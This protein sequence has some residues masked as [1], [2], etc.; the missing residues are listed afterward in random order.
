MNATTFA[1]TTSALIAAQST[2]QSLRI[3]LE[4]LNERSYSLCREL[5]PGERYPMDADMRRAFPVYAENE[6]KI[7]KVV[8]Q[9]NLLERVWTRA[10]L[11]G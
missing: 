9:M 6:D 7:A 10:V 4:L 5:D 11:E 2:F 3:A 1:A 8:A